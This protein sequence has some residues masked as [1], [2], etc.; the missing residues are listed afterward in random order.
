MP[1]PCCY[2]KALLA[3]EQCG[4]VERERATGLHNWAQWALHGLGESRKVDQ[5]LVPPAMAASA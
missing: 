3:P 4:S 5:T 2:R 1:V